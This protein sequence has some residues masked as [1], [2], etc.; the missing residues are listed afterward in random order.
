MATEGQNTE[1]I[2]NITKLIDRYSD[3]FEIEISIVIWDILN[4]PVVF[5]EIWW[6]PLILQHK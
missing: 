2:Q 6:L 1:F 5:G 3:A 4:A